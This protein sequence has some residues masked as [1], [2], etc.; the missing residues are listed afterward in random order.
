MRDALQQVMQNVA[1]KRDE[2]R[3]DELKEV[4]RRQRKRRSAILLL[5]LL[6]VAFGVSLAVS[7]PRW[8]NPYAPP[9]GEA[10][11]RDAQRALLLAAAIVDRFRNAN[12]RLPDS[13]AETGVAL[14]GVA[15]RLTPSGYE[16]SVTADGRRIARLG[17]PVDP[18]AR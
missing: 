15:Y 6:G 18:T 11:E 7:L 5:V 14:P 1:D 8:N 12:R 10:A 16:L 4:E 9:T 3:A 17:L 13:L 2:A